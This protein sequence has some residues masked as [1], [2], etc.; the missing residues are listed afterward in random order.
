MLLTL[1]KAKLHSATVTQ[2]DLHYEGSVSIDQDLLD[3]SGIL[4]HE[5]VDIWNVTNGARIHTYALEA[6]RGSKTIGVNGAAARHFAVGDTVIIAAFCAIEA[7]KARQHA[8][9]VVL[10]DKGNEIKRPA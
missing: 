2:C 6:P 7:E 3:A 9:T 8:P 10:L 5:K 1:L 4:P